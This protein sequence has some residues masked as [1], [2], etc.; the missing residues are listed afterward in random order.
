MGWGEWGVQQHG[1]HP[2]ERDVL[3]LMETNLIR[4]TVKPA[5]ICAKGAGENTSV[6]SLAGYMQ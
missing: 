5:H 4:A 3:D 2:P 6:F 1:A